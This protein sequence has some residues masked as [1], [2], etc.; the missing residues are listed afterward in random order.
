[1]HIGTRIDDSIPIQGTRGKKKSFCETS[2]R[3]NLFAVSL[4]DKKDE[5]KRIFRFVNKPMGSSGFV[6]FSPFSFP[7]ERNTF[8][9]LSFLSS[10]FFSSPFFFVIQRVEFNGVRGGR[11]HRIERDLANELESIFEQSRRQ[12]GEDSKIWFRLLL[13]LVESSCAEFRGPDNH[14]P[15]TWQD[16]SG[17]RF[18]RL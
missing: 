1:M 15:N 17:Q 5:K 9:F 12:P 11:P 4:S 14:L 2:G 8:F 13:R 7:V 10:L 18:H 16:C 6:V 3:K